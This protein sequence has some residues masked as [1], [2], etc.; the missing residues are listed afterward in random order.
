[1]RELEKH[2]LWIL[3]LVL[4]TNKKT[5]IYSSEKSPFGNQISISTSESG[6]LQEIIP[7]NLDMV[8]KKGK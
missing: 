8:N 4:R 3:S 5:R 6:C 2:G 1:M 7:I